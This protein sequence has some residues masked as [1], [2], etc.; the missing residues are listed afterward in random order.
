MR[1]PSRAATRAARRRTGAARRRR[2]ARGRRRSSMSLSSA[3]VPTTIRAWPRRGAQRRLA[4]LGGR[5]LPGEQGGHELGS[6]LGSQHP[7]DRPHVL[8]GEHLGRRDEGRLAAALGDLEHRPQRH[9]GLAR[10]DLALHE[11]V[12]RPVALRD[13]ARSGHRPTPGRACAG[14]AAMRRSPPSSAPASRRVADSARTNCRCWSRA[15]CRTNASCMRRV[16]RA[17]SI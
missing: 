7:R 3:C 5:H 9:E 1:R 6:E 10:A 11:P 16:L 12:H 15:T 13:R 17:W 8:A 14:T 4:A 2:R